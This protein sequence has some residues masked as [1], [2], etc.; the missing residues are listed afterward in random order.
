MKEGLSEDSLALFDILIKPDLSKRELDKIKKV[1]E[2]LYRQL[3][4]E[5]RRI[6]NFTAKQATRDEIKVKI[7]DFLWDEKKGL[8]ESFAPGEVDQ[9]TEVVFEFLMQKHK[10]DM[11]DMRH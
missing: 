11:H 9:K 1:A 3:D 2:E 5:I 10:S 8:P 7:K 6:Q 4:V